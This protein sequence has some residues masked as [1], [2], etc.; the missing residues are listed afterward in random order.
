MLVA[1]LT[2]EILKIKTAQL[3]TDVLIWSEY[4]ILN[5]HKEWEKEKEKNRKKKDTV[6][7]ENEKKKKKEKKERY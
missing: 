6:M 1:S 7:K 5:T 3:I 4:W 2:L